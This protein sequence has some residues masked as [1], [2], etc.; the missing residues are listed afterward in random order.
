MARKKKKSQAPESPKPP[1]P[2]LP[3]P[4]VYATPQALTAYG[5]TRGIGRY[6]AHRRRKN[7]DYQTLAAKIEKLVYE[8]EHARNNSLQYKS[9]RARK[10]AQKAKVCVLPRGKIAYR[11]RRDALEV[12]AEIKAIRHEREKLGVRTRAHRMEQSAYKCHACGYWHLTS[13]KAERNE[14]S[15]E[16]E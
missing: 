8:R 14:E 10:A 1:V 15:N 6:A 2:K 16:D 12:L 9:S 11:T 3:E 4:T 5:R 13:M 7:R